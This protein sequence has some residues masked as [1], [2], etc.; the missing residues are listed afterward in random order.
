VSQAHA[1]QA[2]ERMARAERALASASLLAASDQSEAAINRAYYAAF[3]AASALL[4]AQGLESSKHQ[5]V[6]SLFD[7]EFVL[8]GLVERKHGRALHELF[9][10][11]SEADYGFFVEFDSTT[12]GALIGSA[13]DL[14]EVAH[15]LLPSLLE[16]S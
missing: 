12:V 16:S 2:Q 6:L 10:A 8:G 5:G 3:Y 13:R 7:R 14:V 4:A 11:R 9:R 15:E 1:E